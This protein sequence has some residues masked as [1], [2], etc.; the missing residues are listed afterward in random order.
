MDVNTQQC[1]LGF[2]PLSFLDSEESDA[3]LYFVE[4]PVDHL[5]RLRIP[6]VLEPGLP[7][8]VNQI[9]NYYNIGPVMLTLCYLRNPDM[10][11]V[12][13]QLNKKKSITPREVILKT[14]VKLPDYEQTRLIDQITVGGKPA[15]TAF[16][17]YQLGLEIDP[18]RNPLA[19]QLLIALFECERFG[20]LPAYFEMKMMMHSSPYFSWLPNNNV[21]LIFSGFRMSQGEFLFVCEQIVKEIYPLLGRNIRHFG[22]ISKYKFFVLV[23]CGY[24]LTWV[25]KVGLENKVQVVTKFDMSVNATKMKLRDQTR[26]VCPKQYI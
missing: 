18:L 11:D 23:S 20:K 21:Y 17:L 7:T 22:G 19:W 9:E 14:P 6:T 10:L 26:G 3:D 8:P 25:I 1:A 4:S 5:L 13:I 12:Q 16:C 15:V 2:E 24:N